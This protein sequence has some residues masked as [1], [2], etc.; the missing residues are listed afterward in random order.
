MLVATMLVMSF[1]A[2]SVSDPSLLSPF[3]DVLAV[4]LLSRRAWHNVTWVG[5]AAAT[6]QQQQQQ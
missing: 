4:G 3:G 5:T 1:A 2:G 6:K